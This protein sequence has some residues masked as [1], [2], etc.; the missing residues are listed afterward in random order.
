MGKSVILKNN[1]N[2]P[3]YPMTASDLV[4]DKNTRRS[5][6][7]DLAA[8]VEEAPQD[9]KQY[10]RINGAWSEVEAGA[11]SEVALISLLPNVDGI[12]GATVKVTADG[13]ELLNTT[14]E[15]AQLSVYV[16]AGLE[17]TVSVGDVDGFVTP[18]TQ[19]YTALKGV[20]RTVTMTYTESRVQVN[21]LSNQ[22][23][24]TG[25]AAVKATVAYGSTSVEAG[26][27]EWVGLP[28]NVDVTITFP[29]VEGYK[30]PD[31]ITYSHTSGGDAKSGTYQTE[32]VTVTLSADDDS[33]VSGQTVTINGVTQTYGSTAV[34]Q[35][36][37]FGTT[38]EVSVSAKDGY[39]SPESQSFTASQSGRNL[40]W[41]YYAI[42]L[43]VYIQGLSGKLY[44]SD[45]WTEQETPNGIVVSTDTLKLILAL[46]I[47]EDKQ[48]S[49][50]FELP[51]YG[52]DEGEA[53][54]RGELNTKD[55]LSSISNPYAAQAAY[56]Y[57]FPNGQRGY[58]GSMGDFAIVHD[59]ISQVEEL[60][61]LV[62]GNK[63][64][65]NTDVFYWG[66]SYLGGNNMIYWHCLGE[67]ENGGLINYYIYDDFLPVLPM[68][69]WNV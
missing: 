51:S 40:N 1:D 18:E 65:T 20:T 58:L 2:E 49:D 30:T 67:L 45:E 3:I 64:F 14:W 46:E 31:A 25:F 36:I 41:G 47:I 54:G 28:L 23:N 26:N 11:V 61:E 57:I 21:I 63:L 50:V 35:K 60:F 4:Y 15:G 38:Y 29:E 56:D 62:T 39:T 68:T 43:G 22:E 52:E 48:M 24:D 53:A 32:I 13:E 44:D 27:G 10:A 9:G 42:K 66:S 34:S 55:I 69:T 33:D 6:A 19:T 12:T 8:K 17:Y 37:P 16:R 5:V 7:D 59:N